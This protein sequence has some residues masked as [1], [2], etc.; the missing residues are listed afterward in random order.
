LLLNGARRAGGQLSR[1]PKPQGRPPPR[2]DGPAAAPGEQQHTAVS[3]RRSPRAIW[4]SV[5]ALHGHTDG[6]T[7]IPCTKWTDLARFDVCGGGMGGAGPISTPHYKQAEVVG[8]WL[9]ALSSVNSLSNAPTADFGPA[10][11]SFVLLIDGRSAK[12]IPLSNWA[13]APGGLSHRRASEETPLSNGIIYPPLPGAD[14]LA[15]RH[16][17]ARRP[18]PPASSISVVRNSASFRFICNR[19]AV[20]SNFVA[21]VMVVRQRILPFLQRMH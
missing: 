20:P 1:V 4:T 2:W 5:Q 15:R 14:L 19:R 17:L 10:L 13:W 18:R 8:C 9:L 11:G 12:E 3:P 16:S 21:L 7:V 6:G